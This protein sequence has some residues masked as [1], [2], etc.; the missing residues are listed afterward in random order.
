VPGLRHE[1]LAKRARVLARGHPAFRR[2]S[3]TFSA[4]RIFMSDCGS[5]GLPTSAEF[6]KAK[7]KQFPRSFSR[8]ASPSGAFLNRCSSPGSC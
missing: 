8:A 3:A 1:R 7:P 5:C 4:S 2:R 6:V